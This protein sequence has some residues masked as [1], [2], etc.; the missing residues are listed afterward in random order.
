[1]SKKSGDRSGGADIINPATGEHHLAKGALSLSQV[2]F[3][4]VTGAA[5]IAAMLFNG[6]V[7]ILGVGWAAPSAFI[8]ATIVLTIFS[9]GYIEMARRV[10]S[11]GGFYSFVTHGF[12]GIVGMG[13]ALLMAFCYL[14]FA[15]AV[16]GVTSY[17]AVS[18][19]QEWFGIE[20]PVWLFLF[21]TIMLMT[22]FAFFHIEITARVLGYCLFGELLALFGFCLAVAL[23]GGGP[24]GFAMRSLNP[25]EMWAPDNLAILGAGA[26]GIGLFAAFWSWV[27]FEM[28]PNY[29]EEAK[30]P[31]K[32]MA[33]AMYVSVIGLGVT[34][35]IVMWM[36][37]AAAG[38]A[39]APDLVNKQFAG[40]IGSMF[41]PLTQEY[42]GSILTKA[43]Q[44]FIVTGSFACQLAFFNTGCRYLFSMGREG[45]LPSALG[46]THPVHH[47]THVAGI[48]SSIFVT[49]WVGAFYLYDPTTLAALTK[50]GTWS[51]LLGVS[52]ILGI[53]ALV[54]VAILVYF[55][56][57]AKD[58][59]HWFK[60][61]V[62]PIVAAVTQVY[63][64]YL[65]LESRGTLSGAADVPF[66]SYLWAWAPIVFILGMVIALVIRSTSP[67]RFARIGRYLHEDIAAA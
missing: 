43:F 18:T 14:V 23:Q 33:P 67:A 6:P 64:V 4:C 13:T 28:A 10:S 65:L 11:A 31:K 32:V 15:A 58:G 29:A 5:P 46:R 47:S 9:V 8:V 48:V 56:N 35:T 44:L 50:L 38:Y 26:A 45:A 52:G 2:L 59:F 36:F 16:T 53:Q 60:T 19:I 22:V 7:S 30:E 42:F 51:P 1:M 66:V 54:S 63:A 57:T 24:E 34:Y 61:L 21:G 27:G 17:F 49:V 55:M 20:T 62:C 37:V 41:Y 39:R 40:E 12:G 25:M 3:C